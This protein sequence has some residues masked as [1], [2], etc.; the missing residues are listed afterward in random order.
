MDG[1][2]T[3]YIITKKGVT[4]ILFSHPNAVEYIYYLSHKLRGY[5]P[6]AI[7]SSIF[8]IS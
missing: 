1:V 5:T 7:S 2:K 3:D 8:A 6:S 4:K